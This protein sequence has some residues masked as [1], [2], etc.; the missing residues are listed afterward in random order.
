MFFE[1]RILLFLKKKKQKDFILWQ[2]EVWVLCMKMLVL[3]FALAPALAL[4]QTRA[5]PAPMPPGIAAPR[6][7]AYPGL[8]D[9]L[10]DAT[11][12]AHHVFSAT[13]TLPVGG[14]GKLTLLYAKFLPGTHAPEGH[15]ASFAGLRITGNGQAI[16]WQRDTVNVYAF[17]LDV[18]QGV[19]TIK[20]SFQYLSP[21]SQRE[22][23]V[24]M[25]DSMLDLQW[26]EEVLYPA[27]TELRDLTVRPAVILPAD[28]T[29]GTALSTGE[30]AGRVTTFAAAKLDVLFDS[31]LYAGRY[32][33]RFDLAPGAKT[34]VHLDVVADQPGDLAITPEE[35]D[36]HRALI[37]QAAL[38]FASQH[39]DHFDFLLSV[40]D[41]L[42]FRGLEHH[43]SSE[44]GQERSYF[45]DWNRVLFWHDLLPHEYI[46]SWDGKFRRPADLFS[47]DENT[48]PERGSL[49][50]VY[51]GQTEYWGQVLAARAG[52]NTPEQ[53]RDFLA[54]F[55][56]GLQAQPGREWRDLQD[57]TNDPIINERRPLAW[58]SWSRAEDYYFEG[59][60]MWLDADTLI[61]EKTSN[62]KSLTSF[63]QNFFGIDDGSYDELTYQFDDIV[64]ALN[65]TF[66]YDW[67]GFL[68]ERLDSHPNV[69]LLDGL[70]RAGW[71]LTYSDSESALMK[72]LDA[73]RKGRDFQH[74]VG[75][76][77]G[78][79][80]EIGSVLWNGPAYHA[81]LSAGEK[82]MAVNDIALDGPDTLAAAITQAKTTGL[83][84]KLL[85]LDSKHYK[86]A[87]LDY[88]GGLRYPH[89]TRLPARED[90]LAD[91]IAPLK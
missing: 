17:H 89:L 51:E 52:L 42:T 24:V 29:F 27:G 59:M 47:T 36:H 34:P 35:L 33:A 21:P 32:F 79:D 43:R 91:I 31:P 85:L 50:W 65:A 23:D 56:A 19:N 81:G 69:H 48:Q 28:W 71:Q 73:A 66:P 72:S 53:F 7:A 54:V 68:R 46:H 4:A 74:S 58:P 9:L 30:T 15:I 82:L 44:N 3:V 5:E 55:A 77:L 11:D 84:I 45:T 22:G 70:T 88:H 2:A 87:L 40:S 39:Y 10:V 49:L 41:E 62:A 8:I 12:V 60:L 83:P 26:R 13:E 25:T 90:R 18:P 75:I 78:A 76:F 64:N 37:R 38:N 86:T 63:A 1:K 6:D 67:R 80:G 16:P 61:R 14:P 20:L 57:T